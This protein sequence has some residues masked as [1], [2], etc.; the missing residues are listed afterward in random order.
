MHS[1]RSVVV[2]SHSPL[3]AVTRVRIA[4]KALVP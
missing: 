3:K 1:F 4:A 2:Q